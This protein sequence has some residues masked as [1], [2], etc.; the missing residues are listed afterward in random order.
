MRIA[1]TIL[2]ILLAPVLAHAAVININTADVTL[3]DTLPGIGPAKAEAIIADRTE[4]GPFGTIEDIMRVSGI[5]SSIF[6][7]I[8]ALITVSDSDAP[9][10]V[11]ETPA[12]APAESTSTTDT[13]TATT[14]TAQPDTST[15]STTADT[16]SAPALIN[17]NT[18]EQATLE[19]LP[20]IGPVIA[21]AIIAYRTEKGPFR[22]I[23]EIKNVK[24]IGQA[25]FENIQSL[26][27]VGD[28]EPPASTDTSASS[29][30][31]APATVKSMSSP[32]PRQV[33]PAQKPEA[34]PKTLAVAQKPATKPLASTTSYKKVQAVGNITRTNPDNAYNVEAVRAPAGTDEPVP[35]GAPFAAASLEAEP[36]GTGKHLS[37]WTLGLIGIIV[38]A[39]GVFIFI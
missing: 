28:V 36:A 37:L 10:T 14:A 8:K 1:G 21:S 11:V 34:T 6:S 18:A 27:T 38:V 7:E 15:A 5:K 25:I 33:A 39:G 31:D 29:P 26:I 12:P 35:A 32:L 30:A 24:G 13:T 3:L 9:P 16:P 19:S 4:K 22:E 23:S 20:K 2:L 17:I